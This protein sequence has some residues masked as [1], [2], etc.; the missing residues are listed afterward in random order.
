MV[1]AAVTAA[2]AAYSAY[3]ASQNAKQASAAMGAQ[4]NAANQNLALEQQYMHQQDQLYKPLMTQYV[5]EASGSTPLD[6][7]ITSGAIQNNYDAAQRNLATQ[8]AARGLGASGLAGAGAG[9]LEIGRANA[10]SSAFQQGMV[11]RRNL[12]LQV[13]QHYNP[14]GAVQGVSNALGNQQ[15]MYGQYAGMYNQ[16]AAQGYGAA[17]SAL[18]SAAQV[19]GMNQ[20]PQAPAPSLSESPMVQ[21]PMNAA[22]NPATQPPPGGWQYPQQPS[23]MPPAPMSQDQNGYGFLPSSSWLGGMPTLGYGQGASYNTY[24]VQP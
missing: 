19:Y 12:G 20:Q 2:S 6:Y 4:Q 18:G 7:G 16:A 24:A 5:Q 22:S 15:Q 13:L 10:L 17:S 23:Y 9:G 21:A 8:M 3:S 11:N 1:A 14:Q